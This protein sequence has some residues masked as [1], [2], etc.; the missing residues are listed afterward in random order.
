MPDRP[1]S[2]EVSLQAVEDHPIYDSDTLAELEVMFGR[3]HLMD[4]LSRLK[5]EIGSRLNGSASDRATLGH[6]AHTLL[7][8]SGSLGFTDLSR[9]CFEIERACLRGEDLAAPLHAARMAAAGAI[10]AIT[11]LETQG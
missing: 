8:V 6:D 2:E 3:S 11:D 7:S 10:R 4:L 1:S 9:R 5:V